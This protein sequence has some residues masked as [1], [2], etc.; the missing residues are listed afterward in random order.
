GVAS[1]VEPHRGPTLTITWRGQQT[2]DL[3]FV[4]GGR[5]VSQEGRLLVWRRGKASEVERDAAQQGGLVRLGGW[6]EA[7]LFKPSEDKS[8]E[9]L[10]RPFVVLDGR[11]GL[12]LWSDECPMVLPSCALFD[13][14]PQQVNLPRR[15][16]GRMVGHP[17]L[18]V[19]G[20][21]ACNEFRF[22]R[23]SGHNRSLAGF[24]PA[25]C[26]FTKQERDAVFLAHAAV[27]RHTVLVQDGT[28]IAA[29]VHFFARA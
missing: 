21:D 18:G 10:M 12:R 4:R 20:C 24:S 6:G 1:Q 17:G 28:D 16:R 29:E 27:A 9:W 23:L 15:Q 2:I 25:Q 26:L 7:F 19:R 11:E 14:S 5:R 13:P 3:L 8:I 22:I